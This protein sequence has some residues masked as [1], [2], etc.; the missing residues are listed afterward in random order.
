MKHSRRKRSQV[1]KDLLTYG[2][3]TPWQA[4]NRERKRGRDLTW[5][6]RGMPAPEWVVENWPGSATILA[7]RCRGARDGKYV[8]ETRHNVTILRTS[9]KGLMKHV[10]DRWSYRFA[11]AKGYENSWH[12]PRDTQLKED[13]HRY[14]E[15]NGV[16]IMATL[17]SLAMNALRLDGFWSITEGLAALSSLTRHQGFVGTAGLTRTPSGIEFWLTSNEPWGSPSVRKDATPFIRTSRG[18]RT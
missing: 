6:L 11:E 7:V 14:R 3:K 9:A 4:S 17:R 8:D 16:Q 13:A 1:I 15:T 12:W 10:R 5:T 2:R 18:L